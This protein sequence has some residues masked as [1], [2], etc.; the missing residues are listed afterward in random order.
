MIRDVQMSKI[1]VENALNSLRYCGRI[2]IFLVCTSTFFYN[3]YVGSEFLLFFCYAVD[4]YEKSVCPHTGF[5]QNM[6]CRKE[7]FLHTSTE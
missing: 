3:F 4:V 7:V 2:H 5:R 1:A 6:Y